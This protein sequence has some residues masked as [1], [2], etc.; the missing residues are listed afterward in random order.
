MEVYMVQKVVEDMENYEY[1]T[2][3]ELFYKEEDAQTYM[4]VLFEEE[5]RVL[6]ELYCDEGEILEDYCEIDKELN[7]MSIYMED[8][9]WV[10]FNIEKKTIMSM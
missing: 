5:V 9:Y 7:H 8:Q 1:D 10:G 4:E 2:H 6:T 3:E